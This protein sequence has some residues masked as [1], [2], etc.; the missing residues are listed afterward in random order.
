[1]DPVLGRIVFPPKQFPDEVYVSYHYAF[2]NDIGGGQYDR[3][4]SAPDGAFIYQVGEELR[5]KTIEAAY[6][7]WQQDLTA[8]QPTPKDAVIE[9][10]DNREYREEIHFELGQRQSLQLRAVNGRRPVIKLSDWAVVEG[11]AGSRFVLDGILL[12]GWPLRVRG[13]LSDLIIRHST[14]LPGSSL[15]QDCKPDRPGDPSLELLKTSAA[16]NIEHSILGSIR[17]KHD[18]VGAEPSVIRLADSILDA[19]SPNEEA[20][21]SNAELLAHAVLTMARSTVIGYVETHAFDLAENC[22]FLGRVTVGRR[23]RGCMRFCYVDPTLYNRDGRCSRTPKRYRCQP[24][25]ALRTLPEQ[26][27]WDALPGDR[28]DELQRMERLRVQPTFNALRYGMPTYCQLAESCAQEIK[29]GADDQSEMG[30]FHDLYEPQRRA[31]LDVRLNEYT[32]ADTDA[33]LI[34]VT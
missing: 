5:L 6:E 24:D 8:Y 12:A 3:E 11:Q 20:L 9:I 22:V 34:Y 19:T 21:G 14:L 31:L 17:V 28:K 4:L 16:V 13:E 29:R 18:E 30:A 32:P 33:G 25:S 26:D 7:A 10:V 27:G 1:V 15:A 23:Q 2:S